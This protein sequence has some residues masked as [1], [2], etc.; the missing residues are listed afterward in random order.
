MSRLFD[1]GSCIWKAHVLKVDVEGSEYSILRGCGLGR[2][3]TIFLE[4]H[5]HARF[6]QLL[7]ERDHE[8][9]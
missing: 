8:Y 7:R 3:H 4:S 9:A 1:G 2:V 6:Q 5:G